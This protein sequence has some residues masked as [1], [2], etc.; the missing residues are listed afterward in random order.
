MFARGLLKTLLFLLVLSQIA[1]GWQMRGW[2]QYQANKGQD[3]EGLDAIHIVY[4]SSDKKLYHSLQRIMRT[5]RIKED[6]TSD[7]RLSIGN[8]SMDR[9]PLTYSGAS[10]PAQ[11]ELVIALNF[12][13]TKSGNQI[14]TQR[15]LVS[16][17]NYDF[18]PNLIIA[19]DQE[20]Q[21][22]LEEMRQE[23]A[24]QMLLLLR[25]AR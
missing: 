9:Q 13:A 1:C 4:N 16:R 20:E 3:I 8:I 11:Y 2:E 21:Q 18:D 15:P 23:L 10:T 24:L 14:I 12:E 22:L 6:K 7:L 5:Q 25:Q 17:R 19:K